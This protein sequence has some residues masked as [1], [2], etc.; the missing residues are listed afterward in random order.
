M[1]NKCVNYPAI[2][3]LE[4]NF[5]LTPNAISVSLSRN[6][7]IQFKAQL[8]QLIPVKHFDNPGDPD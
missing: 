5:H 8:V 3:K 7:N 1:K 4:N 2:F 6:Y